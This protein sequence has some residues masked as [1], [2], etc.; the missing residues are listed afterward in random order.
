MK[1]LR[2]Y[3]K[4]DIRL[5]EVPEPSPGEG[6]VKIKVKWCGICGSD[7]VDYENGPTNI[8]EVPITFGHEFSG[9]V[10]ELGK[11]VKGIHAG[12]R[13][14]VNPGVYCYKCHRCLHDQYMACV[15]LRWAGTVGQDG[16]FAPYVV[17][18]SEQALPIPEE[19][20][21]EAAAFVEPTMVGVH[22]CKRADL[23]PGDS[24]VVIGA[25][26]IGL[27]TLQ[28]AKATGAGK[29]FVV[30]PLASRRKIALELGAAKVFSPDDGDVSIRKEVTSLTNGIR[31]DVVF[32]CAG[33]LPAM[34]TAQKLCRVG[35][36]IVMM[37]Q[38]PKPGEFPFEDLFLREQSI[39]SS[40][41]CM[42]DEFLTGIAFLAD[43]R[44][45]VEPLISSRI[46]LDDVIEK[47]FKELSFGKP[48][49]RND[50][51]CK[52]LVSPE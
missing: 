14:A 20:S 52:I 6:E 16:A 48:E 5:E 27:L 26:P 15:N 21:Y 33:P 3:G 42:P 10:V 41:G 17:V 32:Q 43:G 22:A 45:K 46:K 29:V 2:Y 9:E 23:R 35:G 49:E 13:V 50:K 36:K 40:W 31:A 44:V 18:A 7:I 12:D 47:G 28:V 8:P 37:A 4:K 1:A 51:H 24:V 19:V 11:G 39:I 25:G 34:I 30:E 38:M